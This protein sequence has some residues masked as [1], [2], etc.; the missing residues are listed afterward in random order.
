M[1]GLVAEKKLTGKIARERILMMETPLP[2]EGVIEGLR[3]LGD[4]SGIISDTMDELG[5]TGIVPASVLK[6][7]IPG[8]C[9]VGTA[10]TVRNIV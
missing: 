4:A 6:P 2:P 5:I 10:L 8:T 3:E 1:E 7:T 9:V